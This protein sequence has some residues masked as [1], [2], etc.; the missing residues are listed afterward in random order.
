MI[1]KKFLLYPYLSIFYQLS[2]FVIS[3]SFF[4]DIIDWYVTFYFN[5]FNFN[6]Y[7]TIRYNTK[8]FNE[9]WLKNRKTIN[10]STKNKN[11]SKLQTLVG[12]ISSKRKIL[13]SKN[14]NFITMYCST[15]VVRS[16]NIQLILSKLT[17]IRSS[18]RSTW[19]ASCSLKITS[20]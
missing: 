19:R 5:L 1:R 8:K 6:F 18:L 9:I 11:K 3:N 13:H 17:S 4:S 14:W 15:R 7:I 16:W 20:G 12:N 10:I 2:H